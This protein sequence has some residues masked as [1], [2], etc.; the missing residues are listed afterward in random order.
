M[1][2]T[3]PS[4]PHDPRTLSRR[5]LRNG[6]PVVLQPAPPGSVTMA[7]TWITEGGTARDPPGGEG[8]SMALAQLL[9]AGTRS[10]DK[11][12][13]ARA[14]DECAGSLG[15]EPS[16]EALEVHA[17]GPAGSEARLLGLMAEVVSSPRLDAG[18][19]ARVIRQQEEALLRQRSQPEERAER[20]LLEAVFPRGH[21]YRR[22]PLGKAPLL[23]TLTRDALEQF[24]Q[25]YLPTRGG[26]LVI[27]SPRPLRAL[28]PLLERTFGGLELRSGPSPP[29][30]VPPVPGA[31]TGPVYVPLAGT[32]QVEVLVGR[33]VPPRDHPDFPALYLA[34]EILGARPTISRLFQVV[35]ERRGFT[36]G[37]G[38]ELECL[39]WG[40]LFTAQAGT[41]LKHR[42]VVED[43]L[44]RELRR[45]AEGSL[46]TRELDAIRE[47]LLGSLPLL[48]E[49]ARQAHGMALTVAYFDLPTDHYWRWPETLRAISPEE[50]TRVARRR[51][52]GPGPPFVVASGP[53]LPPPPGSGR[54]PRSG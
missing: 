45:L 47:S 27:T 36:Y 7:A 43:L 41:D 49:S 8:M 30:S 12:A 20:A 22:N 33:A 3:V 50:V 40:G 19:L 5:T 53:P 29:P 44:C 34:N 25:H 23:P 52:V 21:P 54:A 6:L 48:W 17:S 18:E 42:K 32:V 16:W 15:C 10:L 28:W 38:S 35:R 51:L 4:P 37:V 26:R 24:H 9:L 11:R 1:R 13:F 14:L 46:R 31:T 2:R 39:R